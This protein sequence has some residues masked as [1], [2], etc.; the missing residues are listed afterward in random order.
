MQLLDK[1]YWK[2][3]LNSGHPDLRDIEYC[4]IK[5]KLK[6]FIEELSF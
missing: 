4:I 3:Q 6:A 2:Q 5:Q 1:N